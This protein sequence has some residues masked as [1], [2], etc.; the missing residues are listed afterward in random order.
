MDLIH[1]NTGSTLTFYGKIIIFTTH[2][3]KFFTLVYIFIIFPP[4]LLLDFLFS[5]N[6]LFQSSFNLFDI[7]ACRQLFRNDAAI[8]QHLA[9]CTIVVHMF[10]FNFRLSEKIF[11]LRF[12]RR[13][14]CSKV[15][16]L[17]TDCRQKI[18]QRTTCWNIILA[19]KQIRINIEQSL[20][21]LRTNNSEPLAIYAAFKQDFRKNLLCLC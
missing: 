17:D 8:K 21:P 10:L 14:F 15:L 19:L 12:D 18:C 20:I 11:G 3:N 9:D 4:P 16:G 5:I 6:I 1:K 2:Q 13:H 7:L